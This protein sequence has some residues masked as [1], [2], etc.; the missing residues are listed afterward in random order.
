MMG[1]PCNPLRENLLKANSESLQI[2]RGW[3][4]SQSKGTNIIGIIGAEFVYNLNWYHFGRNPDVKLWH[5]SCSFS[6]AC[7]EWH[8]KLQKERDIPTKTDGWIPENDGP[9]KRWLL[10]NIWPFLWGIYIKFLG[11]IIPVPR[12][13][14]PKYSN[15]TPCGRAFEGSHGSPFTWIKGVVGSRSSENGEKCVGGSHY[16]SMG[17]L[18]IYRSMN[19]CFFLMVNVGK[20][21]KMLDID[22]T[23]AVF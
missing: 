6:T 21:K 22:P 3:S 2:L 19:A 23:K 14:P 13:H 1:E 18:Y 4:L 5:P 20:Y 11:S 7:E 9:W 12:W 8:Y 16:G 15:L 17:R 10:L